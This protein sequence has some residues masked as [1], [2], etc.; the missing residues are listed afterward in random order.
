M[1]IHNVRLPPE[2]KQHVF[3]CGGLHSGEGLIGRI[4]S[5]LDDFCFP[6]ENVLVDF[7][8]SRTNITQINT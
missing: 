1:T 2:C 4:F 3:K 7:S 5:L 6:G 8:F